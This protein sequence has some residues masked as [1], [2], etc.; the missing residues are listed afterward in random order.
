MRADEGEAVASARVAATGSG[1]AAARAVVAARG[2]SADAA[3]PTRMSA[4]TA[5]LDWVAIGAAHDE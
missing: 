1:V 4:R 2:A 5:G 3:A